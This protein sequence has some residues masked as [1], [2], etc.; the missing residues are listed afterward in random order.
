MQLNNEVFEDVKADMA[1]VN[2]RTGILECGRYSFGIGKRTYIM[3]IVNATPDSF[4]DGGRY[5]D[6]EA[7]IERIRQVIADGA[8]IID[9]GGESTRP[10]Y[11]PVGAEEEMERVMPIIER[12]VKEFD[13]PVSIDTTKFSVADEAVRAGASV[14]NDIWGLHKE[15]R[16]AQLAAGSGAGL[17]MMHN[18]SGRGQTGS[19]HAGIDNTGDNIGYNTGDI[20]AD[21]IKFLCESIMIAENAGLPRNRMLIDPGI[22]FGKTPDQNL[23]ALKRLG[24]LKTLDLPVLLGT[25]RKS[26]IKNVIGGGTDDRLEG[27]AATAA[28]GIAC[29][30]DFIRVHD[31]REI[32]RVCMM[33]DAI[34]R[35]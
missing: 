4:S 13:I 25:S 2:A 30:A 28:L 8:D 20:M 29:G 24:E 10:G 1:P 31:V 6:P 19:S 27:T 21:I 14:I 26:L 11:T 23:D 3:A 5:N 16:L 22:G 32:K 15:P 18:R 35:R 33:T 34:V 9:V 17:V 7:A 12:A